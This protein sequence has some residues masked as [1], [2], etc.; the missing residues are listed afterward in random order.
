[1]EEALTFEPTTVRARRALLD[2]LEAL[3]A[4]REALVLV[5]AQA[6]YVYT[7]DADVPIAT[8]TKDADLVFIPSKLR[9]SPQIEEAMARAGFRHDPKR[10]QPGEWTSADGIPVEL[11][12]PG[13][14]K[15]GGGRRAARIPA[16]SKRVARIVPGLE[17]A[18]VENRFHELTAL[19]PGDPR[20]FEL[21]V[22]SPSAL[23]VAKL[24]KIGERHDRTPGRL[25]DKDAHDL[26]RLLRAT[27]SD[28]IA[29]GLQ[30]LMQN[31]LARDVTTQAVEWMRTLSN[32]PEAIIPM[33]AGRTE[34]LVGS[35]DDV[36]QATWTLIQDVL[37]RLT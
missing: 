7:G 16:H 29:K 4:Q 15:S 27:E 12:V 20:T 17:A 8:Y 10:Q 28:E 1:V 26:Y 36:A 32:S 33:M 31:D 25:I 6:I 21:K 34:E 2:A 11:L 13:A 35:R 22:A 3:G 9:A 37:D 23:V 24:F 14:F 30:A 5:G 19:D 18:A